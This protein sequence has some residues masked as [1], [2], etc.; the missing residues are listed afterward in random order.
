MPSKSEKQHNFMQMSRSAKG[1]AQLRK[2]GRKPAPKKVAEEYARA[3][4]R[5]AKKK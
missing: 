5:K 3:D 1:R 4:K 2:M